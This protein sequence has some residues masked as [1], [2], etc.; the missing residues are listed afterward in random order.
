MKQFLLLS[1]ALF[2]LYQ[3]C[4]I[5]AAVQEREFPTIHLVMFDDQKP[6]DEELVEE[7]LSKITMER[8]G[9]RVDIDT[10]NSMEYS[11]EYTL[12]LSS[13]P[14]IDLIAMI[15]G[16]DVMANLVSMDLLL[17]LEELVQ[18]HGPSIQDALGNA[19]QTGFYR[20][21]LYGIPSI[22]QFGNLY[23]IVLLREEASQCG[24]DSSD[25]TSFE[26][27]DE[28]F[29]RVHAA[30]P[31][32][33]IL[34]P[35]NRSWGLANY[36]TF[37]DSLGDDSSGVLL[38][39]GLSDLTVV[40]YFETEEYFNALKK[41]REWYC[42]GYIDPN[43]LLLQDSGPT[44]MN[45][46]E[47]FSCFNLIMLENDQKNPESSRCLIPLSQP[48][49]TTNS[50]QRLL[51]GVPST[52]RYPQKTVELLNLMYSDPE[53]VNL[54][55]FGIEGTHY[56]I[57]E[58]GTMLHEQYTTGESGYYRPYAQAGNLELLLTAK[59]LGT[60]FPQ[61]L[62]KL[63]SE[64]RVSRAYGFVFDKTPVES[65]LS[66][67]ETVLNTYRIPLELGCVDPETELPNMLRELKEAGIDKVIR[68]K[69]RQLNLWATSI[70]P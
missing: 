14:D 70:E 49:A 19:L 47:S 15:N 13:N 54:L 46:G 18:E 39:G 36:M 55:Q 48:L 31:T 20:Q 44:L 2:T 57:L 4:V 37:V 52:C 1:L 59:S 66:A 30:M 41:I 42:L 29:A 63:K 43:V 10:M 27:L 12:F 51:W 53:V 58:D 5:S 38:N 62:Q 65:E 25:I 23:G 11:S 60:D 8:L 69:Q 9:V 21:H 64:T 40:N 56:T 22:R 16:A 33:T 34:S 28:V 26:D 68:E 67:I 32:L 35:Y 3:P 6:T 17:P 50:S 7:A 61:R 24:I 45:R